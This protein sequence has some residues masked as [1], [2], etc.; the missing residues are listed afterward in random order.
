MIY[1]FRIM[2]DVIKITNAESGDNVN[3]LAHVLTYLKTNKNI[4]II[5]YWGIV[6]DN[7]LH[8]NEYY[9]KR[10]FKELLLLGWISG[11]GTY[12][13]TDKFPTNIKELDYLA[14][15]AVVNIYKSLKFIK[16]YS[17]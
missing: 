14:Y 4:S 13:R 15:A 8:P 2:E 17:Y 7:G 6:Q 16:I 11:V 12:T 5:D 1:L 3:T 9:H 10:L